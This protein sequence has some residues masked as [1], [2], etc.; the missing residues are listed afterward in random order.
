VRKIAISGGPRVDFALDIWKTSK[1]AKVLLFQRDFIFWANWT[2]HKSFSYIIFIDLI[3][4][5][6]SPRSYP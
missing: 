6:L 4:Q 5:V 2:G 3:G 1:S